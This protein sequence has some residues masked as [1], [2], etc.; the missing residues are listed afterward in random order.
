MRGKNK[1][2]SC[3]KENW[4]YSTGTKLSAEVQDEKPEVHKMC[5][6]I[7]THKRGCKDREERLDEER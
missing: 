1:K 7:T 2:R 4:K 5:E 3:G 6:E